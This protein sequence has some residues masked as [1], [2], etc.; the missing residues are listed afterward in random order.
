MQAHQGGDVVHDGGREAELAEPRPDHRG[1]GD[2][3]V[4]EGHPAIGQQAP[5]LR[6]AYIVQQRGQPDHQIGLEPVFGLQGDG[7]R[8]HGQRMLVDVLVPVVLVD[9]EPQSG[10]LG[11]HLAGHPGV[12]QQGYAPRRAVGARRQ[13]ELD[14]LVLDPFR[15]HH[16][17]PRGQFRHRL[18]CLRRDHEAQ[19]GGEAGRAEHAQRIVIERVLRPARR[20][21]HLVPDVTQAAER[22]HQVERGQARRHRIDR[23]VTPGQV[24][25]Q[26]GSVLHAR[27]A[28]MRLVFLAA[29][30]R[31][32]DIPVTLAQADGAEVDSHLPDRVG[33]VRDDLEHLI[34]PRVGRQVEIGVL[35]ADEHIAHGAADQGEFV[36]VAG[37]HAPE[38]SQRGRCFVQQGSRR[39]ALLEGQVVGVRH[40]H[41]G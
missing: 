31:D 15:R 5:G 11:Q 32:L 37:K 18:P 6:L 14:E 30:G 16:G 40:G 27:L 33:P 34:R 41:R 17:E 21:Q 9:L 29:V 24:R 28:R 36:T 39:P 25:L 20:T 10:D 2:L 8:K 3:V 22:V 35:P 26:R 1:A 38:R 4:M 13:H 12:H 7:L 23:E 19:L